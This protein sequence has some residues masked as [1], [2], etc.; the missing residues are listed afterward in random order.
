LLISPTIGV[1]EEVGDLAG[2]V[3]HV[4]VIMEEA[5]VMLVEVEVMACHTVPSNYHSSLQCNI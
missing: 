1:V 3:D 5:M 2:V 4:V